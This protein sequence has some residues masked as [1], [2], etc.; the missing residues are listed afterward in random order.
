MRNLTSKSMIVVLV[1]GLVA[2]ICANPVYAKGR[3]GSRRSY[4]GHGKGS[5]YVGPKK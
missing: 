1:V 5:H 4:P 2:M 3:K